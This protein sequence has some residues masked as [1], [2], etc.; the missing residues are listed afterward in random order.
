MQEV[1]Y[2][3]ILY[4]VMYIQHYTMLYLGLHFRPVT[5]FNGVAPCPTCEEHKGQ[6]YVKVFST[7]TL[8]SL[9]LGLNERCLLRIAG[10]VRMVESR[11]VDNV[12]STHYALKSTA[13]LTYLLL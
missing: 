7:Q 1:P 4:N 3:I 10:N 2:I 11:P 13:Y 5:G 9:M 6:R 12:N 8:T